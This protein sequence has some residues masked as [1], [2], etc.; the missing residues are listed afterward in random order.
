LHLCLYPVV[1]SLKKHIRAQDEGVG[2]ILN[3]ISAWEFGRKSGDQAPLVLAFTGR[4]AVGKSETAFRVA[5]GA[6]A[7]ST[8]I[9]NTNKYRPTG[10]LELR[11]E[12]YT[13]GNLTKVLCVAV[14]LKALLLSERVSSD[15]RHHPDKSG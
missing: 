2:I 9:P 7:N 13:T 6:L 5:E 1:S 8:L 15:S 10:F 3:A 11:G 12:D 4:T 14:S